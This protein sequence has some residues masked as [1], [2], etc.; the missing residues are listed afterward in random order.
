MKKLADENIADLPPS[1]GILKNLLKINDQFS[2]LWIQK[3]VSMYFDEVIKNND[4]NTTYMLYFVSSIIKIMT[5]IPGVADF[6]R[7]HQEYYLKL[8]DW[9]TDNP[10]PKK[11]KYIDYSVQAQ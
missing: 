10:N 7:Q 4:G 1:M 8:L 11:D 9:I 6:I 3:L 2:Q 5:T